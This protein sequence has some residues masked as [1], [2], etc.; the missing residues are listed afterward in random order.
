MK[1]YGRTVPT[2]FN[3]FRSHILNFIDIEARSVCIAV[4]T[5]EVPD[6]NL[7]ILWNTLGQRP[8]NRDTLARGNP[9]VA[10]VG[11][12]QVEIPCLRVF[13]CGAIDTGEK[14]LS[15][16]SSVLID[17]AIEEQGRAEAVILIGKNNVCA[18][19]RED[20]VRIYN[21][22]GLARSNAFGLGEKDFGDRFLLRR[23]TH[24]QLTETN[25]RGVGIIIVGNSNGVRLSFRSARVDRDAELL[26]KLLLLF[27][28]KLTVC[29][30]VSVDIGELESHVGG[31]PIRPHEAVILLAVLNNINGLEIPAVRADQ[32]TISIFDGVREDE[33]LYICVNRRGD[34]TKNRAR[35]R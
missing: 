12:D 28:A 15:P 5:L 13:R 29:R 22:N 11:I 20:R 10:V 8:V 23:R 30:C 2:K 14:C 1:Y 24:R 32:R 31:R 19:E 34:H 17:D 6:R 3:L 18:S 33:A 25:N 26:V 9:R 35:E 21:R 16:F 7:G 27:Q 4:K